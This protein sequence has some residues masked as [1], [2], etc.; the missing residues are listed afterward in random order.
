M[1]Q[2][3]MRVSGSHLTP[4]AWPRPAASSGREV[5]TEEREDAQV[6]AL[7][8]VNAPHRSTVGINGPSREGLL[9]GGEGT[10]MAE[11]CWAQVVPIGVRRRVDEVSGGIA[12]RIVALG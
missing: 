3:W 11:V 2:A 10:E 6:S 5:R 9:G 12:R 7:I 1:F 8:R 4:V